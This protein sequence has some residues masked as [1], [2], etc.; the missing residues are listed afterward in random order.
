MNHQQQDTKKTQKSLD[1]FLTLMP[2]DLELEQV[3]LGSLLF[4]KKNLVMVIDML[5]AN[6]FYALYHQEIFKA[7]ECADEDSSR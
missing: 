1:D 2:F 6:I 3:V 7:R 5:N 4:D